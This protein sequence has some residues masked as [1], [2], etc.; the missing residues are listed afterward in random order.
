MKKLI[1][2]VLILCL[3]FAL[4][5][6][7]ERKFDNEPPG[8]MLERFDEW[9]GKL[10][11]AQ[12]TD[13][14]DLIGRR[15]AGI[16]DYVG[17]YEAKCDGTSGRDVIFGGGSVEERTLYVSGAV[18]VESGSAIVRTR[19]NDE[20]IELTL[21]EDGIFETELSLASGGNYIMVQYEDFKG[22][23]ELRS[24]YDSSVSDKI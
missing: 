19:L 5:C 16:D 7:T 10:G 12:I 20:V 22:T 17:Y 11:Q 1:A 23:V 14:E 9:A 18:K 3:F 21:D 4:H 2:I 24:A 13:D 6:Y 8:G 15:E